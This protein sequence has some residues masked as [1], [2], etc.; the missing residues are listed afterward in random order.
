MNAHKV[1]GSLYFNNNSKAAWY[2]FCGE[3][4]VYQCKYQTHL[5][6]FRYAYNEHTLKISIE[7]QSEACKMNDHIFLFV[8][9]VHIS[10]FDA[11]SKRYLT[12]KFS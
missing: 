1:V 4:T 7:N 6:T 10:L 8:L 2:F 11:A 12:F 5:Y 9:T 3:V